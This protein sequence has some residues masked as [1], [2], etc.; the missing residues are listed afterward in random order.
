MSVLSGKRGVI[1]RQ[2]R[3][4]DLKKGKLHLTRL[5]G[6]RDELRGLFLLP[7]TKGVL[8]PNCWVLRYVWPYG[9]SSIRPYVLGRQVKH[10]L[11]WRVLPIDS[12]QN[13]GRQQIQ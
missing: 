6:L 10:L 9:N 13:N 3:T 1:D 11:R 7:Q 12:K 2:Y 4:N 8:L 5:P